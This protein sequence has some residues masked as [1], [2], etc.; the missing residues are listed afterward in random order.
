MLIT[1]KTTK[2]RGR[3]KKKE[4]RQSSTPGKHENIQDFS[5]SSLS[6]ILYRQVYQ[7]ADAYDHLA[8]GISC[9]LC[10]VCLPQV[11]P[12]LLT[13]RAT[14]KG[15]SGRVK[16]NAI[17]CSFIAVTGLKIQLIDSKRVSIHFFWAHLLFTIA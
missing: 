14:R 10:L 9:F 8:F 2:I 7:E 3:K 12:N 15:K 6:F 17:F 5:W 11:S 16:I 4:S 13:D 1:P